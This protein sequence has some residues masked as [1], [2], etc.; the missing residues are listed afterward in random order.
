MRTVIPPLQGTHMLVCRN[1]FWILD[2]TNDFT[3]RRITAEV[4]LCNITQKALRADDVHSRE[5]AVCRK[6][7]RSARECAKPQKS[8][9]YK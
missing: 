4:F 6:R 8:V 5:D 9:V 2:R 7:P 1:W 3:L